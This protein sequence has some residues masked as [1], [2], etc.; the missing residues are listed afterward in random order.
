VLLNSG[1]QHAWV[2]EVLEHISR[3]N[4][5]RLELVVYNGE[6][7]AKRSKLGKAIDFLRDEKKRSSICMHDGIADRLR[8]P[9]TRSAR[10][11][12]A[13]C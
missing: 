2:A 3:S 8:G 11:I 13:R 7:D 1:F 4:F 10:R 12:A 5:A 6:Q 9:G